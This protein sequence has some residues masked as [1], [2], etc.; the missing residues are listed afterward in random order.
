MENAWDFRGFTSG[1][2]S[3]GEKSLGF[4]L[5]P[6]GV[7]SISAEIFPLKICFLFVLAVVAVVMVVV[8]HRMVFHSEIHCL[9]TPCCI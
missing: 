4:R 7:L 3:L 8:K 5:E 2:S 1:K 9:S 6:L